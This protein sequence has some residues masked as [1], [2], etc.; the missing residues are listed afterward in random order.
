MTIALNSDRRTR[1]KV[2]T[3]RDSSRKSSLRVF[4]L[5]PGAKSHKTGFFSRQ[6]SRLQATRGLTV[7]VAQ[8]LDPPECPLWAAIEIR[9]SES[10][11]APCSSAQGRA[12][13]Q[14]SRTANSGRRGRRSG[15]SSEWAKPTA[16]SRAWIECYKEQQQIPTTRCRNSLI[17]S[18]RG[19]TSSRPRRTR[20]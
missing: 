13:Q 4:S 9:A 7:R 2:R 5:N 1:Q 17:S 12:L 11:E 19:P 15:K 6:K 10:R 3:A 8:C 16:P 18:K 20:R 14:R